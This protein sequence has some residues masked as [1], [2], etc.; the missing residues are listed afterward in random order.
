MKPGYP[1]QL[2]TRAG[3]A[4]HHL[5]LLRDA[6]SHTGV[7]GVAAIGVF[8]LSVGLILA[9]RIFA[10]VSTGVLVSLALVMVGV[11]VLFDAIRF[12]IGPVPPVGQ[13]ALILAPAG[14]VVY[15]AKAMLDT[16]TPRALGVMAV[17]SFFGGL[18]A[19]LL[20]LAVQLSDAI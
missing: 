11:P 18:I 2:L 3:E 17:G 15:V 14:I 10:Q 1:D 8:S 19:T 6:D 12:Q 16:G 4:F 7:L 5:H 20:A 13:L 9:S